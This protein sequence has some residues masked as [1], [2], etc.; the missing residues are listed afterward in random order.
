M[1]DEERK[2]ELIRRFDRLAE[3]RLG[4][5]EPSREAPSPSGSFADYHNL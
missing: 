3:E 2:Q 4:W 1:L 5:I